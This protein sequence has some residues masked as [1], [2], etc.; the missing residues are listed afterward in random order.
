M[1]CISAQINF[2]MVYRSKPVGLS[3]SGFGTLTHRI[4][5]FKQYVVYRCNIV[6][7]NS[8]LGLVGSRSP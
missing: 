8:I 3:D 2:E 7:D 4:H 6:K 5:R 1:A